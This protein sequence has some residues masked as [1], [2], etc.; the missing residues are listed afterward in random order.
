MRAL[1]V[2][3]L[4]ALVAVPAVAAAGP[5]DRHPGFYKF[6]PASVET[7]REQHK[8]SL[9]VPAKPQRLTELPP[10]YAVR[11][12]DTQRRHAPGEAEA[13]FKLQP[14]K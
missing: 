13:C 6:A 2:A 8:Q 1:A 14:S 12:S 10:A 3:L 11:L 4:A 5:S 9:K 7:C